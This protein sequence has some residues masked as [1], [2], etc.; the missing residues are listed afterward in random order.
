MDDRDIVLTNGADRHIS[1]E[2]VYY[3]N[4]IKM[5]HRVTLVY[6]EQRIFMAKVTP[7]IERCSRTETV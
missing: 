3:R 2:K 7:K 1:H 5:L 6:L 4:T